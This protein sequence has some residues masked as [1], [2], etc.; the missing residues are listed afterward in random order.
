M[1]HESASGELIVLAIQA[2]TPLHLTFSTTRRRVI[3]NCQ[4]EIKRKDFLAFSE[5]FNAKPFKRQRSRGRLSKSDYRRAAT[6]MNVESI[7]QQKNT[8]RATDGF[9]FGR[10]ID[11]AIIA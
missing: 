1:A 6:A 2:N 5:A 11:E 9:V 4:S 7:K 8:H 10:L 3:L